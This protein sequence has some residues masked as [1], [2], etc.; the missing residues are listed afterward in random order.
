MARGR[1]AHLH[2]A[3]FAAVTAVFWAHTAHRSYLDPYVA[4]FAAV[5][6][7]AMLPAR[8]KAALGG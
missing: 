6:L 4:A 5:A 8:I 1:A 3:T 2:F 7:A